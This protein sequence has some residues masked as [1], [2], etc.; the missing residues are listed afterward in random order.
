MYGTFA[1]KGRWVEHGVPDTPGSSSNLRLL[2]RIEG[3]KSEIHPKVNPKFQN[4]NPN[5]ISN[6]KSQRGNPLGKG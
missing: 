2:S 4:T 1:A 6:P 3:K 5:E